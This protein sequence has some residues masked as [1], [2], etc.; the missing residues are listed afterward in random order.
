MVY[1]NLSYENMK[2]IDILS[3]SVHSSRRVFFL[4]NNIYIGHTKQECEN[5]LG[6]TFVCPTKYRIILRHT[7]MTQKLIS[8]R[9]GMNAFHIFRMFRMFL[10]FGMIF[11]V[12]KVHATIFVFFLDNGTFR[13]VWVM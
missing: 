9:Y 4:L 7:P 5:F 6:R 3:L 8:I 12:V 10:L 2:V 11:P 13:R 1:M